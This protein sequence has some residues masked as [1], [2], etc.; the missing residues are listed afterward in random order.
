MSYL[1]QEE[2]MKKKSVFHL[3]EEVNQEMFLKNDGVHPIWQCKQSPQT[4]SG[5]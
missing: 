2:D 3:Q 5:N 4:R 1:Q